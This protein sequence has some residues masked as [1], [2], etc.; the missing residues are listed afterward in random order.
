MHVNSSKFHSYKGSSGSHSKSDSSSSSSSSSRESH[1]GSGS[2]DDCESFSEEQSDHTKSNE[3][4]GKFW[5]KKLKNQQ[6]EI[7]SM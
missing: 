5:F 4:T 3:E 7:C 1:S 6:S 2:V